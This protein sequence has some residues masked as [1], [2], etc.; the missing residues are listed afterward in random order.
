MTVGDR[1]RKRRLELKLTQEELALKVGYTS[2][3]AIARIESGSNQLRQEM[4]I[5]F[6]NA[7]NVTPEYILGWDSSPYTDDTVSDVLKELSQEYNLT[8]DE[9]NYIY[10]SSQKLLAN[11]E[12]RY[13]RYFKN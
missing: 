11:Q 1:I 10:I 5:T 4:I 6:A 2:R 12:Y 3:S 7:L 9:T 8:Q 13:I